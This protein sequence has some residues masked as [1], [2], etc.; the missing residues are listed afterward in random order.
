MQQ[1]VITKDLFGIKKFDHVEF[2]VHDVKT[3]SRYFKHAL[4]FKKIAFSC[5]D[6]GNHQ[7]CSTVLTNNN[8]NIKFIVTAPYISTVHSKLSSPNVP[9]LFIFENLNQFL[10]DHGCGVGAIC[11]EV[12][13]INVAFDIM[14]EKGARIVNFPFKLDGIMLAEI[15]IYGSTILRL[16][17]YDSGNCNRNIPGY[18]PYNSKIELDYGLQQ[19]DHIVGNVYNMDKTINYI[20]SL[21]GMHT[22]AKFTK[23]DI[24]T[25][26]TSLNSEVLANKINTVILPIN[27]PTTKKKKSQIDE[28]LEANNGEGV[29]HI[30][31]KTNNICETVAKMKMIGDLGFEFIPTPEEYYTHPNITKI[32]KQLPDPLMISN[33]KKFGILVDS[34]ED[35]ILLQIFTKPLFYQPTIFI[36]IIQRICNGEDMPGCGGFGKGNFKALFESIE[37]LQQKRKICW[38]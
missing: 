20:K 3:V 23:D 33:I 8:G 18:K 9:H 25:K 32:L 17:Q 21:T 27:E 5:H 38:D 35:G 30:A 11:I 36:E 34:D 22:F 29:Q 10:K 31:L 15:N 6:T 19:I 13:N 28:F 14:V 26:W 2:F 1:L 37:Y 7:Y 12:E 4:G 24:Q 16:I